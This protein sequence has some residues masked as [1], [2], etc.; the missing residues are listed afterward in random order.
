METPE[1]EEAIRRLPTGEQ[2][3][4][5]NRLKVAFDLS[6]KQELLPKDKWITP[7]ED[8]PYLR[9]ILKEVLEERKERE[10]FRK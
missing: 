1:V 9:P 7:N 8:K 4:R 2:I 10:A 3:E 6:V 5:Q